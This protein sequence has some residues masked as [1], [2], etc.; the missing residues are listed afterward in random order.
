MVV[1]VSMQRLRVSRTLSMWR[2]ESGF[3]F[4][5]ACAYWSW[6]SSDR[7]F[8]CSLFGVIWSRDSVASSSAV[9]CCTDC[10]PT[11]IS[12]FFMLD[13]YW[14]NQSLGSRNGRGR[15]VAFYLSSFTLRMLVVLMLSGHSS[16]SQCLALRILFFFR[17]PFCN[18]NVLNCVASRPILYAKAKQ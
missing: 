14:I 15:G 1:L 3:D 2:C 9:L 16:S 13:V 10:K 17:S 6:L 18:L 4:S 12:C 11:S 8:C 5:F 7:V